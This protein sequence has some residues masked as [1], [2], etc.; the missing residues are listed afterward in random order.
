MMQAFM[1]KLYGTSLPPMAAIR[2]GEMSRVNKQITEVVKTKV[3]SSLTTN[4]NIKSNEALYY[5][6]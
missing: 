2:M 4:L 1:I 3:N 6:H 5:C